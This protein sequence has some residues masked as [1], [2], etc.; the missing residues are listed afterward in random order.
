MEGNGR[1]DAGEGGGGTNTSGLRLG[2]SKVLRSSKPRASHYRFPGGERRGKRKRS[3]ACL[4][5]REKAI[6]SQTNIG[7]AS[8]AT[9]GKPLRQGGAHMHFTE[10][11]FFFLLNFF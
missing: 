4:K 7:T 6:I 8:K 3:R 11:F 2:M 10:R 9:L 1:V 5:G